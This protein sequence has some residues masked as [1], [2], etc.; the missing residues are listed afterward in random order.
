MPLLR[1]EQLCLSY[2]THCLLDGAEMSVYRTDR[3]AIVGRNGAG[4]STLLKLIMGEEQPDSGSIWRRG[5]LRVSRLEQEIPAADAKTVFEVVAGGLAELGE[6]LVAYHRLLSGDM[7]EKEL[8]QMEKLQ[9]KIEA[10]DGWLFQQKVENALSRL[11]LPAD[12]A[13]SSLS[14]GWRRR[15]G[16]ARALVNEPDILL[17]DEPTNHL[18]IPTI[19]WLEAQMAGFG[20]AIVFISHDRKF[21]DRLANRIVWL[22]RGK[23][24]A[25][26]PGY[27]AFLGEREH[28]LEVES[29]HNALFDKR[30]AE[31]EKW[32]RQGIKARRT[33]NEGRVRA[34]E[35]LR[36]E[37]ARR[38]EGEG[39]ARLSVDTG[40]QSGKLVIEA[41]DVAFSYQG[42]RII[43]HFSTS[44]LRGDRVGI[45]G[46]NGAG[47]S[48]LIKLLL[49]RL[50]PDSGSV[51]LGSKLQIAYFDQ[52]RSALD[53][54]KTVIDN[55]AEGREFI[56]I[57]GSE[58]HVISYLNDF[59]F[60]PQRSRTPV[61]ALS[62]G[63]CN[64]LL[65]AKLFSKKAN[66]L[67]MDEPTNDLDVETLELLEELLMQ[68]DGTLLLVSHDR[69]FMDNVVTNTLIV[70]GDGRVEEYVGGY[71]DWIRQGGG[72]PK[73]GEG[74][75]RSEVATEL[76][77]PDLKAKK[78]ANKKLGYKQQ[79]E[80]EELPKLIESMEEQLEALKTS[81]NQAD[82]Y[83]QDHELVSAELEKLAKLEAELDTAY[84]RWTEL[85]ESV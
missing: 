60:T 38:K 75:E 56:E 65:L 53:P 50:Q 66:L 16:L 26:G 78:P 83:Q 23:L 61:R 39:Q 74:I 9:Q 58:R 54:E 57:N 12:A 36:L 35:S 49:G 41:K 64:R 29:R 62:G 31:E 71:S 52:E 63:E 17:L 6:H 5:G 19:E 37:R 82:F 45:I 21:L 2:G 1:L 30:L 72:W 73:K 8:R 43:D 51:K 22:D 80:L 13:M 68:F 3:I 84:Q 76:P 11:E 59:L 47:K 32:I 33:R 55:I 27:E 77:V 79:R 81:V 70:K 67:V 20:G 4:K 24:H 69:H 46:A 18:D 7:G 28:F 15:V 44:I 48:T 14:G 10:A 85:E 42:E 34:L 25:F 40:E